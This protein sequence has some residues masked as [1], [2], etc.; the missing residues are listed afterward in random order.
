MSPCSYL[1]CSNIHH[2][3]TAGGL[4]QP[5]QQLWRRGAVRRLGEVGRSQG[6]GRGAHL[7][8]ALDLVLLFGLDMAAEQRVQVGALAWGAQGPSWAP[9]REGK[10]PGSG[11]KGQ[12]GQGPGSSW[13]PTA[14]QEPGQLHGAGTGQGG[15]PSWGQLCPQAIS[16]EILWGVGSVW[17]TEPG[18]P[19][20]GDSFG[21]LTMTKASSR[22]R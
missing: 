11:G 6:I 5:L 22:G 20:P 13:A 16:E 19:Q 9:P 15:L 18:G 12:E 4:A 1:S 21:T 2:M 8:Q 17:G 3:L 14:P 7:A 10:G